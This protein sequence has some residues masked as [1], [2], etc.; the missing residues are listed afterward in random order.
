[1]M[2]KPK[3]L[4]QVRDAMRLRHMSYRTE[5]AYVNWIRRFI[6]LIIGAIPKIWGQTKFGR[7]CH[8]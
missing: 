5:E 2:V 4:D 6:S 7:F 1:M 3:L 8:T